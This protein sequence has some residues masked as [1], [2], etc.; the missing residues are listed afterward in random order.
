MD[1]FCTKCGY[2]LKEGKKFC[3]SCG[4]AVTENNPVVPQQQIPPVQQQIPPQVQ[5]NV[6][7]SNTVTKKK[8]KLPFIIGGIVIAVV[9]FIMI[10]V[11]IAVLIFTGAFGWLSRDNN[12]NNGESIKTKGD[13]NVESND[14]ENNDGDNISTY[15]VFGDGNLIKKP[16][17]LKAKSSPDDN[18]SV[19]ALIGKWQGIRS[20]INTEYGFTDDGHFYKNVMIT[21][22]HLNSIYHP[23]YWSYGSYYD[24]YTYGWWENNW[25]YTY[26][27]LDTL[28]GEYK[29]KGGV[30]EFF[31]IVA[32]NRTNFEDDWYYKN[33]RSVSLEQ[34]QATATSAKMRDDFYV[35]FEFINQDRIRFRDESDDIDL[36]WNLRD[37]E[38]NVA[39]PKHEIPPV[40]WPSKALSTDMPNFTTKGRVREASLSYSG[41]DKNIKPEFKTVTIVMDKTS[42]VSEIDAYSR[43]LKTNGWWVEDYE[44]GEEATYLSYESRKG[45]FK[46]SISNGR[47]SGTSDDTIVIESTKYPEGVW[48]KSWSA[49]TLEPPD[50]SV[51][52]G[53]LKVETGPDINLYETI[54][55]DK[56]NEANVTEYMNKLT[57]AGFKKPHYSY[58]DWELMK[59]IRIDKDLYLSK[60][61]LSKRMD[62]LTSFRYD[63]SY[64]VDGVWPDI[65][66]I[67]GL[68]APEG[69]DTIAGAINTEDWA[70]DIANSASSYMYIKFLGID[71][72]G[73]ENYLNKLK[74]S[75]FI[76]VKDDWSDDIKF[77]AYLR[78]DGKMMRV[79]VSPTDNKDIAEIRYIFNYYEDGKWPDIWQSGGLPVPEKYE[80]IIGAIDLDKW[81]EDIAEYG[82]NSYQYI[83]FLGMNQSDVD[84]YIS[85]LKSSGFIEI[86]DS[87]GWNSYPQYYNYIRIDGKLYRVEI[88]RRD[89][90]ELT[91]FLYKFNYYEDGKWPAIWQS[92]S[93][94]APDGNVTIVGAIDLDKWKEDIADYGNNSYQYIKFLG[95]NQSDVTKYITKLKSAGFKQTENTWN[96]ELELVCYLRIDGSL[97]R[98]VIEQKNNPELTEFLYKF[99]YYEDGAWPSKWTSAGIPAPTFTAIPG[100]IEKEFNESISDYGSYYGYIKLLGANLS[101]YASVLKRNGFT[102]VEYSWTDTWE[103][104]KRVQIDGKWYRVTIEDKNNKEIPEISISIRD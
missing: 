67:G 45:M 3:Q 101:D 64:V 56:V 10:I 16:E 1:K 80:T 98:I 70:A 89:N 87:Y 6:P 29:V 51:I 30:I 95:M 72:K 15:E 11:L 20:S 35:E 74:S 77:Y 31:H 102:E 21:H 99:N 53:D 44:L 34:L 86:D 60:V 39:I 14:K 57:K 58:D 43:S 68:F 12:N 63:M 19:A 17:R 22:S 82:N 65:W 40:D 38:H 93:L 104:E 84:K 66:K 41:S 9:V 91:E 7:V 79:E 75:G 4:Q 48:P 24:T 49:A 27:Y 26:T 78:I 88:E 97:Y 59:Y 28:I 83:K 23:G 76:Q 90:S 96:D 37:V 100:K 5:K 81:R 85:K 52:V 13:K 92:G 103:L 42:A 50:N 73:I 32:I 25:S 71:D 46:L 54:I 69:Y 18:I 94:P 2:Q 47:G 62:S 61:S 55:F 33:T 36:F 8:S